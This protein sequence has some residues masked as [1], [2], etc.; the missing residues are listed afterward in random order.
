MFV[1]FVVC[2]GTSGAEEP[3]ANDLGPDQKGS[4]DKGKEHE[5]EELEE[6]G[7]D[8]TAD[9]AADLAIDESWPPD[10]DGEQA[11]RHDGGDGDLGS[12]EGFL[13]I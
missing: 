11:I 5:E 7:W 2:S 4:W 10:Q 6:E 12:L 1:Q 13:D 9:D 3:L 8:E